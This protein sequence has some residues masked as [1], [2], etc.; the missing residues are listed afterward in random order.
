MHSLNEL[1][2][3]ARC[4]FVE[5]ELFI[6]RNSISNGSHP[7]VLPGKLSIQVYVVG[8]FDN[9]MPVHAAYTAREPHIE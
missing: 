1:R 5:W 6:S 7:Y 8:K 4:E 2:P 3:W 9:R